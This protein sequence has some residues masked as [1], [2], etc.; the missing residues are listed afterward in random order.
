MF[1]DLLPRTKFDYS[2]YGPSPSPLKTRKRRNACERAQQLPQR[3]SYSTAELFHTPASPWD[4]LSV[5]LATWA[6]FFFFLH[7]IAGAEGTPIGSGGYVAQGLGVAT[8]S[9]VTAV[10][11]VMVSTGLWNSSPP[12]PPPPPTPPQ[13]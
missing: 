11:L 10:S 12:P 2:Y 8:I 3:Q 7:H 5:S 9:A 13:T 4:L 6:H 1:I